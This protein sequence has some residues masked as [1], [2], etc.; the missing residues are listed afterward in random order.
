MFRISVLRWKGES[1]L[2]TDNSNYN[3]FDVVT[4]LA[5][6]LGPGDDLITK[7]YMKNQVQVLYDRTFWAL[8]KQKE[9]VWVDIRVPIKR[10]MTFESPGTGHGAVGAGNTYLMIRSNDDYSL[11]DYKSVGIY[12]S[13]A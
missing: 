11:M 5:H 10:Q 7:V 3:G 6:S 12:K 13:L 2:A 4:D 9:G 8:D 1:D